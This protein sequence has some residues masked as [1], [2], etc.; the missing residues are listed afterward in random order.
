[1]L[2]PAL[3]SPPAITAHLPGQTARIERAATDFEALLIQQMLKSARESA[4]APEDSDGA[5]Q[6]SAVMDLGE[7]QFAEALAHSG[8]LGIAKMVVAG[9]SKDANR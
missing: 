2:L 9:L 7:Q 1:M 4:S 6:N 5:D 8:G 3:Q